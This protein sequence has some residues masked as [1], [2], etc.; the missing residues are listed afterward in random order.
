MNWT[1]FSD[2]AISYLHILGMEVVRNESRW[3]TLLELE[4]HLKQ[5]SKHWNLLVLLATQK[6]Q[7]YSGNNLLKQNWI[8]CINSVFE[9]LINTWQLEWNI[10]YSSLKLQS[11]WHSVPD[12]RYFGA[13]N[14]CELGLLELTG[15][16]RGECD[17]NNANALAA[18]RLQLSIRRAWGRSFLVLL[19][20]A[21]KGFSW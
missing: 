1:W 4:T 3:F 19:G 15:L 21:E 13:V 6:W 12:G 16:S 5:A 2:L 7:N 20:V 11:I 10:I 14:W 17:G 8:F 18:Q 9:V